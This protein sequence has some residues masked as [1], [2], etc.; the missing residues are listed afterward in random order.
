[1]G[2]TWVLSAPDGPHVG[3]MNLANRVSMVSSFPLHVTI[4][5]VDDLEIVSILGEALVLYKNKI[6]HVI[7]L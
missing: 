6:H 2:P 3:P 7:H 1:M 4:L 5:P